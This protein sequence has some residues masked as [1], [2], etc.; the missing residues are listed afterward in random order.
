MRQYRLA[1]LAKISRPMLCRYEK[2]RN[3]PAL[4][5][6]VRLLKVLDCDAETFGRRLGPWCLTPPLAVEE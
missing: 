1:E 6:L 5:I 3:S 2:G 4:P